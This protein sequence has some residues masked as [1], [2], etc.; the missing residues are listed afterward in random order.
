[1]RSVKAD[2]I[3]TKGTGLGSATFTNKGLSAD[4]IIDLKEDKIR[5]DSLWLT[6]NEFLELLI[7]ARNEARDNL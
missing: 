4:I 3:F 1:M 5:V 7:L 6:T 2:G